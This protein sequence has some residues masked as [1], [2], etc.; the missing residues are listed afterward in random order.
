MFQKTANYRDDSNVL[1][2]SAD[3]GSEAAE[4][5]D[6]KIYLYSSAESS[7]EFLN[8]LIILK[9]IYLEDQMPISVPFV[10]VDFMPDPVKN[11]MP[12]G[13]GSYLFSV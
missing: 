1:A 11:P 12:E 6:N 2:E 3:A 9:R 13:L 4:T 8:A 10:Q 7:V 5:P